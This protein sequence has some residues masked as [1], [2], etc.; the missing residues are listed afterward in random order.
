MRTVVEFGFDAMRGAT[1]AVF[2]LVLLVFGVGIA[3]LNHEVRDD[4]MKDRLVIKPGLGE[5]DKIL[6]VL[7]R[8]IRQE[9][10]LDAAEFRVNNG[11]G[12]FPTGCLSFHV[13]APSGS[14]D[15][16]EYDHPDEELTN[17]H[18]HAFLSLS[19]QGEHASETFDAL[20]NGIE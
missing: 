19:L 14:E 4:A 7:R 2:G 20:C 17:N 18:R 12:L 6:H 15:D 5:R 3:P 1:H 16:S 9:A 11:P 8:F 13:C 10:H